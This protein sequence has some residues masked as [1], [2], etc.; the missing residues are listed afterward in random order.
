M[1]I[2]KTVFKPKQEKVAEFFAYLTNSIAY[3]EEKGDITLVSKSEFNDKVAK[4]LEKKEFGNTAELLERAKKLQKSP[5]EVAEIVA[6]SVRMPFITHLKLIEFAQKKNMSLAD[7]IRVTSISKMRNKLNEFKDDPALNQEKLKTLSDLLEEWEVKKPTSAYKEYSPEFRYGNGDEVC[8]SFEK[9]I[10]FPIYERS[11]QYENIPIEIV[12]EYLQDRGEYDE[13][14]EP[15]V[16]LKFD[17]ATNL[18]RLRIK[19]SGT[20]SFYSYKETKKYIDNG[21]LRKKLDEILDIKNS[22]YDEMED[23]LIYPVNI[24]VSEK[25]RI[26]NNKLFFNEIDIENKAA[27]TALIYEKIINKK[28]SDSEISNYISQVQEAIEKNDYDMAAMLN[29]KLVKFQIVNKIAEWYS[30][31]ISSVAEESNIVTFTIP[32]LLLMLWEAARGEKSIQEFV[33]KNLQENLDTMIEKDFFNKAIQSI[34]SEKSSKG[35]E[36]E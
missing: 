7:T 31:I 26:K 28:Y 27:L 8:D 6:K 33:E 1:D 25:L 29:E 30:D 12:K 32:K 10:K 4:I 9:F 13:F 2:L 21:N 20:I 19:W 22:D 16:E 18:F 5:Q 36:N 24:S 3:K 15:K 35:G 23:N 17:T 14:N 34:E 11:R